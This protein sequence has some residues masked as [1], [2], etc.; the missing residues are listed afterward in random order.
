[1][2]GAVSSN[3]VVSLSNHGKAVGA[4]VLRQAQDEGDVRGET[5]STPVVSL[6][7]HG[8]ECA[9]VLRQ[10]QDEGGDRGEVRGGGVR[11]P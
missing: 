4:A 11:F 2:R 10:A 1:M 3:P 5:L 7:N 8:K 6:S 9:A